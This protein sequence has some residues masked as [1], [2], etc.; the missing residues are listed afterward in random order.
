MTKDITK[1]ST[2]DQVNAALANPEM[3]DRIGSADL[4][5]CGKMLAKLANLV[6]SRCAKAEKRLLD[7]ELNCELL[8]AR[9]RELTGAKPPQ[10]SYLHREEALRLHAFS[11]FAV[12]QDEHASVVCGEENG[13]LH[14]IYEYDFDDLGTKPAGEAAQAMLV[15][16]RQTFTPRNAEPK[17]TIA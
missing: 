11:G 14:P 13:T 7:M 8:Q 1:L 3:L 6:G 4:K 12:V 9:I 16:L 2:E 17:E 15:H 5:R 10:W